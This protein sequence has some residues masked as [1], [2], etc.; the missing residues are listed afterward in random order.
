MDKPLY[1]KLEVFLK[2]LKDI[3]D[4]KSFPFTFTV[5]DP[6]GNSHVQNLCAPNPDP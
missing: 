2:K 5:R 3:C 1:D 4:G 6:S